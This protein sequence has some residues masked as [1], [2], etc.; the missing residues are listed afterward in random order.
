VNP[1]VR[2]AIFATDPSLKVQLASTL[3]ARGYAVTQHDQL[4]FADEILHRERPDFLIVAETG[5]ASDDFLA[6]LGDA[7]RGLK[8]ASLAVIEPGVEAVTRLDSY[9]DWVDATRIEA[10]LPMRV[11]RLLARGQVRQAPTVDPR[12]LA[13]VVHDLRTPLNVIGLTVRAI[14]QSNPSPNPEFQEDLLFLHENARQIEKMLAQLGDFCRLVESERSPAV[15]EFQPRRFLAEFLE[16]KQSKRDSEYK[17][18]RL[19]FGADSPDEVALDPTRARLAIGHALANAVV[20]AGETPVILRSRGPA[21]RWVI[22]VVVDKSPPPTIS[23]T[24]LHPDVFER[25][26]GSAAERR[27]L[28]LAIAARISEIFGGSANLSVEPGIRSVIVLDWPA[29]IEASDPSISPGIGRP[30]PSSR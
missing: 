23:S 10:E 5:N 6:R 30:S 17:A 2:V 26:I 21:D 8:I 16:E 11:E 28:D 22:E 15:V 25:L 7:A 13:L 24:Q 27:G 3:E 20:A 12:F 1:P 4:T 18:V 9:G 19:E 29:R 14:G